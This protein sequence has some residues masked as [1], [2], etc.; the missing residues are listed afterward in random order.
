MAFH[1]AGSTRGQA[2]SIAALRAVVYIW[3]V[4]AFP[5]RPFG[6]AA[7]AAAAV[8][9]VAATL[10]SAFVGCGSSEQDAGSGNSE[11]AAS[12][13]IPPS[14]GGQSRADGVARSQERQI[15][16]DRTR[17]DRPSRP[18][19]RADD[20]GQEGGRDAA[21]AKPEKA[22]PV[23]PPAFTREECKARIE[24]EADRSPSHPVTEPQDCLEVMSRAQCEEILAAQ[25]G[26][27][28][29][30]GPSIDP[31]TCL[32]EYTREYCEAQLGPHYEQQR[33]A[34]QEAGG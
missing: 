28:A 24:A 20:S 16:K 6:P 30:A 31:E 26:A 32:Q 8:L 12:T 34:S 2:I 4:T 17:P 14:A 33:A 5:R 29:E 10:G 9:L 18:V 22:K 15:A 21:K 13:A 19:A 27:E 3:P 25:R 7:F 1:S 23:C 11:K